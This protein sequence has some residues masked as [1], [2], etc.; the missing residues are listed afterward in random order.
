MNNI[1]GTNWMGA[2]KEHKELSQLNI[3]GTHDCGT[4][5]VEKNSEKYQCQSL[6][7]REQ[8]N[9]GVRYFDIRCAAGSS[10]STQYIKHSSIFCKNEHGELLTIDELIETGKSFLQNHPTESLIF[11]IKNEGGESNDSRLCNHLGKYIVNGSLWA[12]NRI[13]CLDEV[14]GRIVLVR[15]F[16]VKENT[17]HLPEDGFGINLSSWDSECFFKK[18]W[19]TFVHINSKAWV[20]DRY[21]TDAGEKYDLLKQ[22]ID[23]M[24]NSKKNP[25]A[26]WSICL[27]S[28]ISP[29][30]AEAAREINKKLLA[31]DSVLNAKKVGTFVV[32]FASEAL[33]RKIYITNF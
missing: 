20:Q 23:E 14:R 22:A 15:R 26:G 29:T 24:N 16:T 9:I 4:K 1:N 3:P 25:N 7:V 30:P 32:D 13:P 27:S 12:Q 17:Y 6:F 28:C 21:T 5:L 10:D 19:N 8:I 18:D 31:P 2:I 11:Q 33:I